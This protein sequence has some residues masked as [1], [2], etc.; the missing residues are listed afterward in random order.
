MPGLT[1]TRRCVWS[2]RRRPKDDPDPKALA[3]YGLL[4]SCPAA[5]ETLPEQVWL[6]FVE[7][8]PVS[9]SHHA[10]PGLVLRETGKAGQEGVAHDLG[11]RLLAHQ[12]G[13]AHL[14][15]RAT[16][17][18]SGSKARACASSPATCPARAPGSIALSRT[19]CMASA[20]SSSLLACSRL[21]KWPIVSVPTLAVIMSL[22]L[23]SPKRRPDSALGTFLRGGRQSSLLFGMPQDH[24]N[25]LSG[26]ILPVR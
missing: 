16:I 5:P 8:R 14:D 3:C 1:R 21:R 4:V 26:P 12:Q 20:I 7:D 22:I 18:R 15:P 23:L 9:A 13:G 24:R 11:Q 25:H 2:N 17:E 6:R 19:G 10:V